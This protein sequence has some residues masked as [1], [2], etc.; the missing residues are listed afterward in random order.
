MYE[1]NPDPSQRNV[2]DAFSSLRV[3]IQKSLAAGIIRQSKFAIE[4]PCYILNFL[5]MKR[6]RK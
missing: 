5:L 1:K 4:F 2:L 3:A 6:A